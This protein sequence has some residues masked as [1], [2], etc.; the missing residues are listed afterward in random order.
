MKVG[1]KST[2]QELELGTSWQ[3]Q[4]CHLVY[5]FNSS[6]THDQ[7]RSEHRSMLKL[8]RSVFGHK[9]LAANNQADID[10]NPDLPPF[11]IA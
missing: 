6:D 1:A 9:V 8:S 4:L 2:R 7:H 11:C 5:T 10:G 3:S